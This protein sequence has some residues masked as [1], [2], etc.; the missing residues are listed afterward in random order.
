MYETWG[1]ISHTVHG[2]VGTPNKGIEKTPLFDAIRSKTD[3][4]GIFAIPLFGFPTVHGV[5]KDRRIPRT[6]IFDETAHG[7]KNLLTY[8]Y[9]SKH[10]VFHAFEVS[11]GSSSSF[12]AHKTPYSPV[13]NQYMYYCENFLTNQIWIFQLHFAL[14]WIW[15]Y[16]RTRF[17][18]K[19]EK[20]KMFKE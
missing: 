8:V 11:E 1:N 4:N 15:K 3:C 20:T 18:E 19:C 9:F 16:S 7:L 5:R 17:F 14:V 2:T 6:K 12:R 10:Y 13:L